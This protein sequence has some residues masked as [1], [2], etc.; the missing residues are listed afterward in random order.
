[1]MPYEGNAVPFM[2]MDVVVSKK[3]CTLFTE[4][5]DC[6]KNG[7]E[8]PLLAETAKKY[9]DLDQYD[10]KPA[11]YV[12][13][14]TSYSLIKESTDETRVKECI[15]ES[16]RSYLA[17]MKK[18]DLDKVK[19]FISRQDDKYRASFGRRVTPHP[20]QCV[21]FGTTNNENGYLRDITGNRRYWNVKVTGK[22]K[23]KAWDLD[24]DTVQ[25]IWA[26]V[27][28]IA[29]AGEKLYLPAELE[30]FAKDEQRAAMERDDRE[31]LVV[32]YLEMLLPE[33]WESMDVYKRRDYVRDTGD[34]TRKEGVT[35]RMEVSNIEIWAECFG[36][37][38]EDMKNADSYA[39]SA[40]MARL[41]GWVKT[42][43]TK[44]IPIYGK[45][46][47]YARKG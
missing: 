37:P 17:G 4:Y 31:G 7:T 39:I 46:R 23:H 34:P 9:A 19:A 21:F 18:A 45:Q 22:G 1:M 28:V 32:E 5:Y 15:L 2:L 44:T 25:Q 11:W 41:D 26:E 38:K 36:K 24:Q 13:E 16:F 14:R 20:R 42:G 27:K 30:E 33:G 47:I 12:P 3:K 6:T 35:K 43:K 40:I 8:Q 10:E 29:K